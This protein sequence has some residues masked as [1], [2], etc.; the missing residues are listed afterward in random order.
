MTNNCS[1]T[2]HCSPSMIADFLVNEKL[3]FL[4]FPGVW[5]P[6]VK[7]VE[8]RLT[9]YH[10]VVTHYQQGKSITAIVAQLHLSP[11]TMRTSVYAGAFP[12]RA[13]HGSRARGNL[14]PTSPRLVRRVREG[15]DNA[16]LL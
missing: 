4:L 5:P 13:T 1:Q 16:S 3:L 7:Q 15:C 2:F 9:S 10:K 6:Q 12:E 8:R 14:V 11:T